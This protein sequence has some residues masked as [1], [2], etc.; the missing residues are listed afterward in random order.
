MRECYRHE[1]PFEHHGADGVASAMQLVLARSNMPSRSSLEPMLLRDP[2]NSLQL[3]I[4]PSS[5]ILKDGTVLPM[6]S[7]SSSF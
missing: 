5:A 4:S 7:I 6:V 1:H 3:A 2:P